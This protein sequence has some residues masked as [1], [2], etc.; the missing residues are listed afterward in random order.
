MKKHALALCSLLLTLN[1]AAIAQEHHQTDRPQSIHRHGQQYGQLPARDALAGTYQGY[2]RALQKAAAGNMTREELA[3]FNRDYYPLIAPI[4]QTSELEARVNCKPNVYYTLEQLKREPFYRQTMQRLIQ[5]PN[6][7]H[8]MLAY[9]TLASAGDNSFNDALWKAT[10][11]EKEEAAIFWVGT[12]LLYLKDKHTGELFDFL[13][14]H[15]NFGDAHMLPLYV[16]LDKESLKKTA[17]EK[18]Q[19]TDLKTKILA[20]QSLSVTGLNSKT[21]AVVKE[22]CKSL[23]GSAKGY[24][25]YTMEALKMGN[26]KEILAPLLDNPHASTIAF[27]GLINSPTPEDQSYAK[28]SVPA[29]G[30]VPPYVLNAYLGSERPE[31]TQQFLLLVRDRIVPANYKLSFFMSRALYAEGLLPLLRDTIRHTRNRQLVPDLINTIARYKDSDT[32]A[33]LTQLTQ[34]PDLAIKNAAVTALK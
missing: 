27:S 21:E 4:S 16:K 28:S 13:I 26:L 8:R 11:T 1:G 17:Y 19:S 25:I 6:V 14:A 5:S 12:A 31:H 29:R 15:E 34:D 9:M 20:V 30:E 10:K 32:R 18:I 23:P 2:V 22:A 3:R 24:A 33:L 7:Q